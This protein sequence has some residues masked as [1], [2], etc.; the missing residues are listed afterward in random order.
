MEKQSVALIFI[1]K[2]GRKWGQGRRRKEGSKAASWPINSFSAIICGHCFILAN[3]SRAKPFLRFC[4]H[5]PRYKP[6]IIAGA[7]KIGNEISSHPLPFVN[8]RGASWN[9][10]SVFL[11]FRISVPSAGGGIISDV[12]LPRDTGGKPLICRFGEEEGSEE[13]AV[14]SFR[15]ER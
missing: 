9:T 6:R 2:K 1:E 4:Y 8:H 15:R 11:S 13:L 10:C 3:I 5:R 7:R 12:S 14:S